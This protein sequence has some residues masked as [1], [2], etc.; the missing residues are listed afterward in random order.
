[1]PSGG[2]ITEK[3]EQELH[4]LICKNSKSQRRKKLQEKKDN[5]PLFDLSKGA[6]THIRELVDKEILNI[7]EMEIDTYATLKGNMC[8]DDSI[9]L[10]NLLTFNN[11]SKNTDRITAH[12][13]TGECDIDDEKGDVIIDI[14]TPLSKKTFKL[15]LE[16]VDKKIYEW[17][18]RGYM[19]LWNR[20][21]AKLAYCLVNTPLEL[22]PPREPWEWH[23]MDDVPMHLRLTEIEIERD[24]KL[25]KEI[26]YKLNEAQRYAKHYYNL[27]TTKNK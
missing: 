10:L 27:A 11:Y 23:N 20:N 9:D 3:E 15:Y 22:I 24:M 14:K 6:I 13:L 5:P 17:Q 2:K 16:D 25:E 26:L 12:G 18:L 19:L 21:K 8:E 1:M 4:E 7:P